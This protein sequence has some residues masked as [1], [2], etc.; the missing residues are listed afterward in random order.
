MNLI[1]R[2]LS[3]IFDARES[4]VDAR[5][6]AYLSAAVDLKDLEY[7]MRA[8]DEHRSADPFGSGA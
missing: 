2:F 8:L 7:R 3:W 1:S 6:E 4:A 5:A